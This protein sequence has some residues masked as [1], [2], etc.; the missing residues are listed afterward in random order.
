MTPLSISSGRAVV[1]WLFALGILGGQYYWLNQ[2]FDESAVILRID[3]EGAQSGDF[4]APVKDEVSTFKC[5]GNA[6]NGFVADSCLSKT[7]ITYP[8]CNSDSRGS[9]PPD[10][11]ET[12]FQLSDP[13]YE[14]FFYSDCNVATQ[15]VITS[16]LPD[17]N[18]SV[19][20]P[21]LIIAWPS[22]NSGICSYFSPANG[23]NGTLE[24]SIVNSSVGQPLRSIYK[25]GTG[26]PDVGIAGAIRFNT[27]AR[28]GVTIMGSIRTIR[29]FTEG[30]STLVPMIQNSMKTR[31][32]DGD[33]VS[34]QRLWLDNV[35]T[36]VLSFQPYSKLAHVDIKDDEVI[37]DAG[38]YIFNAHYNYPQQE[39][40]D[41]RKLIDSQDQD[42]L[43]LEQD[44]I[45]SL[46]FLSYKGKVLAGAWKFLTYFGR[47]TM[48][49]ALLMRPIL[50]HGAIEAVLGSVLERVDRGTGSAC[51]EEVI[52]DYATY[53]NTLEGKP[54]TN[55]RCDY[56]MVDT[57]Y[58][59]PILLLEYLQDSAVAQKR[60]F[61]FLDTEAGHFYPPN[62][63]L[64]W[65]E[66]LIISTSKIINDTKPF[67]APGGQTRENL[68]H[69]RDDMQVGNWRDSI[70]GLGTG[71]IPFD[72]NTA[73]VP[74]ALHS[75]AT[76]SQISNETIYGSHAS[77]WSIIASHNAKIWETYALPFFEIRLNASEAKG[78]LDS[79]VQTSSYYNGPS[80]SD[81]IDESS[82]LTFYALSLDDSHSLSQTQKI[83]ILNSDTCFHL[84]FQLPQLTLHFLNTTAQSILRP[85]P[86]G[87]MTPIGLLISNPAFSS[88]PQLHQNFT[89]AAYHGTV[90]WGWQLAMMAKG[91]E[92]ALKSCHVPSPKSEQEIPSS[93]SYCTS[94]EIQQTL[95]SAYNHLWDI[96]EYNKPH[97]LDEVWSWTY[98]PH[99]TRQTHSN[100]NDNHPKAAAS[101]KEEREKKFQHK[102]LGSFPAPPGSVDGG[103][104]GGGGVVESN[105]R[106]LWSLTFLAVRRDQNLR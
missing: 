96:I 4:Q 22:G 91:L 11:N 68:I 48:I 65:R 82:S 28:L 63:G 97:I 42:I 26:Y 1:V 40:F 79:F 87:L 2:K 34:L 56:H 80:H 86:A 78:R 37:F 94:R 33:G 85:F 23:P 30:P 83:P 67:A 58:F 41:I 8:V 92:K 53:L 103:G 13:P 102:P 70:N 5:S 95:K 12:S 61:K 77:E 84:F 20:S 75:I 44:E 66:L 104:G 43:E 62:K 27:T 25:P 98:L 71:R 88:D 93:S 100:K 15:V 90:V 35:T 55:I 32:I 49:S 21:R 31:K 52:G 54:S 6:Y 76:L 99:Q 64:T 14:N 89:N 69:L 36:S 3:E 101:K 81:L 106:Q 57:E 60:I 29:D 105:I 46:S 19:I 72:V 17:G 51:H 24:I 73:I 47:D 50:S 16:P 18:L 38:V 7:S 45:R 10:P 39:Q 74:A 9:S 59:I